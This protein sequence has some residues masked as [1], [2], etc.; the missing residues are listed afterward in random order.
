M[1]AS[2]GRQI[3]SVSDLYGTDE[4]DDLL[5]EIRDLEPAS[6]RAADVQDFEIAGSRT[7]VAPLESPAGTVRSWDSHAN[8]RHDNGTSPNG[9]FFS[10]VILHFDET[11][12][13]SST[14]VLRL[15]LVVSITSPWT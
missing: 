5:E 12:F 10:G 1:Q 6:C 7:A 9:S 2:S 11:A 14:G 4:I 3:S 8:Y 15:L 13:R